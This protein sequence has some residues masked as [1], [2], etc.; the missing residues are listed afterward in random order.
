VRLLVLWIACLK[1]LKVV[2][3]SWFGLDCL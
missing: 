2:F 3:K 1:T